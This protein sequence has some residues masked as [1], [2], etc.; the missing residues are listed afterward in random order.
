MLE[1]RLGIG[2]QVGR[3]NVTRRQLTIED[4]GYRKNYR[5]ETPRALA[6]RSKDCFRRLFRIGSGAVGNIPIPF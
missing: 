5:V 3:M 1:R 6:Q 4:K 2:M